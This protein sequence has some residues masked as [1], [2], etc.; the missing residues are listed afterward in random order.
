M[1][2]LQEFLPESMKEMCLE[3][4]VQTPKGMGTN[5]QAIELITSAKKGAVG[6]FAGE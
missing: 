1:R 3:M 5:L 4:G 6:I 2:A